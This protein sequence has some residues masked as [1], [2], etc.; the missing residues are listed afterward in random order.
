MVFTIQIAKIGE[1]Q[2]QLILIS[3]FA[4]MKVCLPRT[5]TVVGKKTKKTDRTEMPCRGGDGA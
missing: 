3:S 1:N 4:S 5:R 2:V